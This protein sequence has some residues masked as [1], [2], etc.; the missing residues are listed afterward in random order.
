[1]S[2][3]GARRSRWCWVAV[4]AVP[5][6]AACTA[7][8]PAPAPEPTPAPVAAPP[9]APVPSRPAPAP[10]E[11]KIDAGGA[12]GLWYHV[13]G[14]G[15]DTVLVPLGAYLEEVLSPLARNHVLI[16]YDPRRRGR[17]DTFTDTTLSSFDAD[18]QDMERVRAALGVSRTGI[19]GFSYYAAVAAAHAARHPDRVSRLV[20]LSPIEPDDSVA[21][22]YSPAERTTRID[23]TQAR[24]LVKRRAAGADTTSPLEYC[25]AYWR[26]N[27]PLFVGDPSRASRIVPS[28]CQLANES[29]RALSD[30]LR[31]SFASLGPSELLDLAR[32]VSAPT[33]IIQ[34]DRDFVVNPAGAAAWARAL[35]TARVWPVRGA[36]HFSFF[37]ERDAVTRAIER[38]LSG[39]WP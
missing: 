37:E 21:A 26:L 14:N 13:V 24:A 7:S 3:S 35:P 9:P 17:S 8:T 25:E 34:G 16:F 29:P 19:I 38:F 10:A 5:L 2:V 33:L 39:E 11:G 31:R 12:G 27:A 4:A 1:M 6:A 18:V 30:H 23:T 15:R 36:G 32:R 22:T 20:M 28:W